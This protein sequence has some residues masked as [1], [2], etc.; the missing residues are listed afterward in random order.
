M[1]RKFDEAI[2]AQGLLGPE[3]RKASLA[4]VAMAKIQQVYRI[5]QET[6]DLSAE[7]RQRVRNE[8]AL[9]LLEDLRR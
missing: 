7:E 6:K 9:P 4:G 1:R 3:K 5:E 2:K 8:T